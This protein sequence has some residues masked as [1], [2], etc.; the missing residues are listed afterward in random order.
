[1]LRIHELPSET[2][3]MKACAS[4]YVVFGVIVGVPLVLSLAAALRNGSFWSAVALCLF[5]LALSFVWIA[6]F[7]IVIANGNISY[8]TLFTGTRSVA[9][10]EIERCD[11]EISSEN[12]IKPPIRLVIRPRQSSGKKPISINLKVFSKPDVLLLMK[13]FGPHKK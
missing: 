12:A 10:S 9:L 1:M 3:I 4:T 13:V 11:L 5:A 7:K 6:S 8:R 2:R